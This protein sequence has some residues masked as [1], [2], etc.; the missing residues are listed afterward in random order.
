MTLHLAIN[1]PPVVTKMCIDPCYNVITLSTTSIFKNNKEKTV[2]T[3]RSI[4]Y[5]QI[6]NEES[7]NLII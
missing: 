4:F 2:I 3:D 7:L 5:I 1:Q 6:E